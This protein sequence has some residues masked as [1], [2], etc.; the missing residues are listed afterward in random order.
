MEFSNHENIIKKLI[1]ALSLKERQEILLYYNVYEKYSKEFSERATEDLRGHPVFGKLIKSMT[2]EMQEANY[3][4]SMSLQKDAIL[5]D[6]WQPYIEYQIKQGITYA[7][8]GLD[9]KS[10]YEVISLVRNYLTPY[11]TKEYGTGDKFLSALNGMNTFMDIAMGI[12]GEAY[13]HEKKEI[14]NQDA[15]KIKK[16]N[17]ELEQKVANRTFELERLVYQLEEYKYFF[18]NSHDFA[19]IANMEGYFLTI[20]PQFEKVLGYSKK[21]LLENQFL[22]FIHPEDIASTLKEV[23]K[24]KS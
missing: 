20:N 3:K 23:E 12:I 17:E 14:I 19:C 2:K 9:F 1:P 22:Q 15:Q 6:K 10:W 4:I 8:M 5:N 7:K 11:L 16:L 13:M 21:E 24:L 18:I